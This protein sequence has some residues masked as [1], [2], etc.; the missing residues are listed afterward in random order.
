MRI[1]HIAYRV[2]NRHDTVRF[3]QE[4][5]DYR[6]SDE[7]EIKFDDESSAQ[8]FALEPP[9]K[10]QCMPHRFI[11]MNV[12]DLHMAPEIFVSDG[13]PDSVVGKWVAKNNGV[14]GIHHIAYQVE[15]VNSS[16][17]NN[18]EQKISLKDS[19]NNIKTILALLK[20]AKE[21]KIV[22]L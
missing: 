5:F 11:H 12:W 1:D 10:I 22:K 19:K 8:C 16:I 6:I 15:S 2:K 4:A 14:G 18:L 13:T 3:F 20:S 9:E 7:F 17:I 21:N